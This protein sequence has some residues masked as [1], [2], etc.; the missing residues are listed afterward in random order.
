MYTIG[1]NKVQNRRIQE[2][3][4]N[5]HRVGGNQYS[6]YCNNTLITWAQ[7]FEAILTLRYRKTVLKPLHMKLRCDVV[8]YDSLK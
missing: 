7:I 2:C 8:S 1:Q 4:F 6:P 3:P 5:T